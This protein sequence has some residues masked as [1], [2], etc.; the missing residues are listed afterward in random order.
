MHVESL[1]DK[2]DERNLVVGFPV[3]K[4]NPARPQQQ[5]YSVQETLLYFENSS[6]CSYIKGVLDHQKKSFK[7]N[8]L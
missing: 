2:Q 6:K 8:Q 4:V 5:Q 3:F 7:Q 1:V